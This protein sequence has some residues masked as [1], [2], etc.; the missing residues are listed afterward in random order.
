MTKSSSNQIFDR[1]KRVFPDGTTRIT[2]D[3]DPTPIYV[4]RGEGAWLFSAEGRPYLDCHGNFTV[5]IHGHAF[6]PVIEAVERQLRL[7]TCFANPTEAEVELAERIAGRVP[8]VDHVRFVNTGTEAVMFAIKAARAVTGRSGIAK[9]EGAYHGAYDWVEVSQTSSPATWGDAAAP[10][11][12][13]FYRGMPAAVVE[14]VV[15]LPLNDPEAAARLIHQHGHRLAAV[16]IDPMPS[17]VGLIP[18][19][20][21]FLEAISTAAR[22]KGVLVIADEVLN[23][24]LGHGGA[25]ARF[26]LRPDLFAFGKIIG[27]GFPIGAVGGRAE[28]MAVFSR[29]GG[30]PAV[31]QGGTF[32]ANPVSMVAGAA[33]LDHLTPDAFGRLEQLGDRLRQ[34]LEASIRSAGLQMSV[35]GAASLLR[36]HPKAA[37]GDFRQAQLDEPQRLRLKRLVQSFAAAG[38]LVPQ[39]GMLCL[40]TAMTEAEVDLVADAFDAFVQSEP[41]PA[42]ERA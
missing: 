12:V 2:V 29:E 33:S 22:A 8:G 11:S 31:P 1:A 38:I 23:F 26:G 3:R 36:I 14:D 20:P 21:G 40:S 42:V 39:S 15:T 17:R 35:T 30:G 28:I 16:V 10:N 27:G 6:A 5:L 34:R 7:G 32:S 13:P 41:N 19:D 18:A 24:R 9:I 25:S 4:T 37:P